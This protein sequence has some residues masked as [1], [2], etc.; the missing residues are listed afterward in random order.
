M[1][2]KLEPSH[3]EKMLWWSSERGLAIPATGSR[4]KSWPEVAPNQCLPSVVKDSEVRT[5]CCLPDIQVTLPKSEDIW[6]SCQRDSSDMKMLL[7]TSKIHGDCV[8]LTMP[9]LTQAPLPDAKHPCLWNFKNNLNGSEIKFFLSVQR[10]ETKVSALEGTW[11]TV[12]SS[13]SVLN[14][15]S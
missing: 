6:Q 10:K 5:T 11:D 2:Q 7:L 13:L 14:C 15:G 12:N 4:P 8:V 1:R 3:T 9:V